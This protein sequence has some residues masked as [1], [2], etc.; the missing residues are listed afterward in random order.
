MEAETVEMAVRVSRDKS[1]D[2]RAEAV[3]IK[4]RP[5]VRAKRS[6]LN[7]QMWEQKQQRFKWRCGSVVKMELQV[8]F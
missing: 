4:G 7:M 2:V 5:G 8:R 6:I 3:K 1:A